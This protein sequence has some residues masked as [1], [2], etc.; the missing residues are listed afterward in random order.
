MTQTLTA[1]KMRAAHPVS[2][3]PLWGTPVEQ[4]VRRRIRA[5]VAAYAYE[6][7]DTPIMGDRTFD[8]LVESI[9]PQLTTGHPLLDEFFLTQFSPMTGMWIHKHPE[10]QKIA[11]LYSNY[12]S[13][14]IKDHFEG[15]KRQGKPLP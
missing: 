9:Q 11:K 12:Y 2:D 14:V 15:L 13:G 10:L 5:S 4:E 7:K 1:E 3:K 6:V 8:Q